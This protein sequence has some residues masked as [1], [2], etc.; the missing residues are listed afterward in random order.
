MRTN[1]IGILTQR[2]GNVERMK[3]APLAKAPRP[4]KQE[5]REKH[6]NR[7]GRSGYS[8]SMNRPVDTDRSPAPAG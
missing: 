6:W 2:Q 3:K 7:S 5:E 1:S 4:E 8:S